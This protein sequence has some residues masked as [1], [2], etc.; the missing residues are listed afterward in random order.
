MVCMT[1]VAHITKD[2]HDGERVCLA[3]EGFGNRMCFLE[4]TSNK[5]GDL[6]CILI[7]GSGGDCWNEY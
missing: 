4:N 5:V 6:N 7:F 3:A 2:T 1:C